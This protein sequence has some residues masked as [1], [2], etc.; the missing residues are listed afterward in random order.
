MLII[1]IHALHAVHTL[2]FLDE[3][4]LDLLGAADSQHVMGIDRALC[5]A[6]AALDILAFLHRQAAA[7]GDEVRAGI[8]GLLVGDHHMAV[9][10][11]L[12]EGDLAVDL[13]DDCHMLGTAR[14]KQ[15]FHAGRPWVI[16]SSLAT[17]P[18]WKV[19]M[20]SWVPGSPMDWAAMMPTPRPQ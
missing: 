6:L 3:V 1:G 14:L 7:E 9:F 13:I 10:L 2:H 4:I 17:P 15:L 18:V 12:L 11:D 19:R 8:A 5:N 16:S 20:V